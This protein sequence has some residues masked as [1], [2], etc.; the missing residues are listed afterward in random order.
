[1][2][3]YIFLIEALAKMRGLDSRGEAVPFDVEWRTWN[4]Q[5]KSGGKLKK[6][7]GAILCMANKK[8]TDIVKSLRY[9]T[10]K[11]TRKNP[12]HFKN[13]TR[14]IQLSD[15]NIRKINIL[16]ITKFNGQMVVY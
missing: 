7:R 13:R 4:S 6:E 8:D 11:R 9:N 5:N 16:L 15:G 1:M 2:E 3:N 10:D 14:N 12:N